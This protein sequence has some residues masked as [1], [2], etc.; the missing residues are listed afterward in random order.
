MPNIKELVLDRGSKK[1]VKK[2]YRPWD[3][4]GDTPPQS[5]EKVDQQV[6][7]TS[8]HIIPVTAYKNISKPL[9][10]NAAQ[11]DHSDIEI[12][13]IK[14]PVREHRDI[15]KISISNQ[16]DNIKEAQPVSIRE[17]LDITFDPTSISNQLIKLSGI[18]KYILN[19]VVDVSMSRGSLETGPIETSTIALYAKT[20]IG[21]IKISIKRLIDKGFILRQK[22]KKAKGGYI[23]LSVN[24]DMIKAVIEQRTKHNNISNP[25]EMMNSIRYQLDIGNTYSSSNNIKTITT[26]KTEYLPEEW[27]EINFDSLSHIGFTKTQIKQL[28][29][30]SEPD[31]V[32]ESINHFAYGLDHN[33][34]FQKYEDPLNVLMGV[35]RKGQGWFEKDYRSPKQIAQQQLID[36]KKAEIERTKEQEENAFKLAMGEWLTQLTIGQ[37]EEIAPNRKA[38]GDITPQSAKLNLYFKEKVWPLKKSEYLIE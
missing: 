37:K 23:N 4:T 19:F 11:P 38:G 21:T 7:D 34:K 20:T 18:Q 28:I 30:K 24:E 29:D 10:I 5:E 12:D 31:L 33:V 36:R 17:H 27:Q 2:S 25:L 22:G 26:K 14:E 13:N 35:L 9:E 6:S 1:F 15:N 8:I 3:L 16:M 32:Q